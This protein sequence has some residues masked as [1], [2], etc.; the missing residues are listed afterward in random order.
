M[1][2]VTLAANFVALEM[3]SSLKPVGVWAVSDDSW[4]LEL[5]C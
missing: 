3:G 2:S 1:F 5:W 4:M